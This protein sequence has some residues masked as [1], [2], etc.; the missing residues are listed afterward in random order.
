MVKGEIE[1]KITG[2]LLDISKCAF[3]KNN[4]AKSLNLLLYESESRQK[5]RGFNFGLFLNFF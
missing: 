3:F 1:K 5:K 2:F 4:P